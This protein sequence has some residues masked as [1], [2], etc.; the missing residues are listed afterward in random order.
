MKKDYIF[1]FKEADDRDNV[2]A[3]DPWY[4]SNRLIKLQHWKEGASLSDE[5]CTKIPV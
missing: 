3:L 1:K 2:L 4:I 5:A